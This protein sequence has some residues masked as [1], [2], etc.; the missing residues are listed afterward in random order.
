MTISAKEL[1]SF[2]GLT[3][4]YHH[5]IPKFTAIAKCLHDL[6]GPA[7]VKQ[8]SKKEPEAM[9]DKYKKFNWTCEHQ[10]AFDLLKTHLM[11]APVLGYPDILRPFDQ[12]TDVTLQGFGAVL[13]QRDGNGKC[14]V[15]TH[16]SR[17]LWHSE[18]TMQKL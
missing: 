9:N 12:E 7:N 3:S 1:H 13:S 10:E 11:S 18:Q 15:I 6:V 17:S 14:R 2:L 16:A 5:F 4:Y 8:K